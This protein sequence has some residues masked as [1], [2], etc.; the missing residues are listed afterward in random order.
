MNIFSL[1]IAAISVMGIF[2][3]LPSVISHAAEEYT[4]RTYRQKLI[5]SRAEQGYTNRGKVVY[6]YS[7]IDSYNDNLKDEEIG[8]IDV[9]SRVRELHNVI[10]IHDDVRSKKDELAVGHLQFKKPNPNVEIENN[11][12]IDGNIKASGESMEIGTVRIDN[13]G[14]TEKVDSTVL[15]KGGINA[16]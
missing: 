10:I 11:I 13:Y 3:L 12:T 15:I 7:E 1:H 14:Q 16:Q 6:S 8:N 4:S 9:Q 2:F 5:K